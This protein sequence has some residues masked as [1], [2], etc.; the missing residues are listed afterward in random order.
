MKIY[1]KTGDQGTTGL[2]GGKRVSKDD[3]RIEAYGT[4]DELNAV[5]GLARSCA[6]LP[7]QLKEPLATLSATLFTVGS[8]LATPLDPPPKYSIPR[9][10]EREI[11]WLEELIDNDQAALPELRQFILPGG[12]TP[13]AYLHLARTVCRRAERRAARLAAVEDIGQFALPFLNRLSDYL[14]TAARRA[15]QLAGVEDIPWSNPALQT[16]DDGGTQ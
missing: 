4:V 1:T 9:I 6:E 8:D 7:D 12:S 14:F 10:G 5:I 16:S 15:N 11:R 2:F 3:A 13:A